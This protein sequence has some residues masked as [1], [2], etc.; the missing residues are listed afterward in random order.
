LKNSEIEGGVSIT[1]VPSNSSD[2]IFEYKALAP[3]W[4]LWDNFKKKK[5]SEDKFIV[6]YNNMLKDL[7]PKH[8]LEHLNFLTGGIEPILMCK[9]AKTKFCHRHLVADW[10][11]NETG[12]IINELNFPEYSRKNGYLVKK[13]NPSLFPD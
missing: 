13:K 1:L 5:I 12:I 6:E 9:P 10:L 3:N 7:N 4:R 2:I 8:V 11:E